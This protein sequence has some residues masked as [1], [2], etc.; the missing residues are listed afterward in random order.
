MPPPSPTTPS[1]RRIF[2]IGDWAPAHEAL[3]PGADNDSSIDTLPFPRKNGE[4]AAASASYASSLLP[5]RRANTAAAA[6]HRSMSLP[7]RPKS[8]IITVDDLDARVAH[9]SLQRS[10]TAADPNQLSMVHEP[11]PA[12]LDDGLNHNYKDKGK[13][14]KRMT[15]LFRRA[16]VSIKGFVHR[17]T[18]IATD[19]LDDPQELRLS[20]QLRPSH[21]PS[22]PHHLF[23]TNIFGPS[24][25]ASPVA[26]PTS[27]ASPAS[28]SRHSQQQQQQHSPRAQTSHAINATWHRLRK[29]TS[30]SFRHSRVLNY[31]DLALPQTGEQPCRP[32]DDLSSP[33]PRPGLG[34]D[35]PVIPRNSGSGARA[36]VAAWQQDTFPAAMPIRN[37]RLTLDSAHNDR[38]SGIGI[39]VTSAMADDAH[40]LNTVTAEGEV[41]L[42][43][44]APNRIDFVHRLP[45]ELAIQVLAH[46]DA[47]GLA[48]ASLVSRQWREVVCTQHVW[49]ES[50]LR[51]KTGT[52][53][54]SEPIAP[55]TGQGIPM[56]QPHIDWKDA[57]R[58]T[59]EL[60]KRWKQGKASSIYLNGHS[61]S[62]Y[63]LQFDEYVSNPPP[64]L[65]LLV[66]A[67]PCWLLT[68]PLQAK[69]HHGLTGQDDSNLGHED[70]G[71]QAGYRTPRGRQGQ[72]APLRRR[73]EA[74]P[75]GL[76][77]APHGC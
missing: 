55:G 30:T 18:S 37:K 69:D 31:N 44:C 15:G 58:A 3:Y 13:G 35:P 70:H 76:F 63:C 48:I 67:G 36:A 24:P 52:Y 5:P 20:R 1:T 29:A 25:V 54:T 28:P 68:S 61:D 77:R 22:Q 10:R 12:Q 74:G 6:K 65:I 62:I 57:Y 16:S 73:G 51:E 21:P 14:K 9:L 38:E 75:L 45:A 39:A 50:Y 11:E 33:H 71:L 53:A 7:W 23:N 47:S 60:A 43:G 56:I 46:L 4:S 27:P 66:P 64:F 59:E 72:C 19:T 49:R 2:P 40:D 42:S 26:S 41:L 17:R 34:N 8:T 32:L